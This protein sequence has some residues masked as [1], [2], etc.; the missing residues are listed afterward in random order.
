MSASST[1][2]RCSRGRALPP[3]CMDSQ[4]GVTMPIPKGARLSSPSS[5]TS[6]DGRSYWCVHLGEYPSE[7]PVTTG[8]CV[9]RKKHTPT[10]ACR[11][12]QRDKDTPPVLSRG[13]NNRLGESGRTFAVRDLQSKEH[14]NALIFGR[15]YDHDVRDLNGSRMAKPKNRRESTHGTSI[16]ASLSYNRAGR[17]AIA[18]DRTG[19]YG[20]G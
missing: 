2:S 7:G 6:G 12:S 4:P 5:R 9:R 20:T 11:T 1:T 15:R 16:F 14:K 18:M 10:G 8:A 17:Y 3:D 13:Q 19:V